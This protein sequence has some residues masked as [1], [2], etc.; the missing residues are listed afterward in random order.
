M[1]ISFPFSFSFSLVLAI[2]R[3]CLLH[4]S[5]F[6][7]ITIASGTRHTIHHTQASGAQHRVMSVCQHR[8]PILA[9]Q[10]GFGSGHMQSRRP[11]APRETPHDFSGIRRRSGCRA[12]PRRYR[13]QM[14][15][16]PTPTVAPAGRRREYTV[17]SA[18]NRQ[19]RRAAPSTP[20][21][22]RPW[23]WHPPECRSPAGPDVH[24]HQGPSCSA[25]KRDAPIS[26]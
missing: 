26:S 4:S 13:N 7:P 25:L 24:T 12:W 18:P 8:Q 11:A 17:A 16:H 3:S 19:R 21:A 20:C 1:C 15:S 14:A 23:R 5:L 10:P 9:H 22:P 2:Q 6:F